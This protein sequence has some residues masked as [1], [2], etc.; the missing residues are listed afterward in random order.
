MISYQYSDAEH[1]TFTPELGN[2]SPDE[3]VSRGL[4]SSFGLDVEV[5]WSCFYPAGDQA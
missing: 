1:V 3:V 5:A 2:I 4:A